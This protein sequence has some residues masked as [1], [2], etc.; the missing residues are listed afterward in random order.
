MTFEFSLAKI[1]EEVHV[2]TYYLAEGLKQ[3]DVD[4]AIIASSDDDETILKPFAILG[5]NLISQYFL[6][7]LNGATYEASGDSI[8]Y[9][10]TLNDKL[11]IDPESLSPIVENTIFEFVVHF[12]IWKWLLHIGRFDL[13]RMYEELQDG[14]F[15]EAKDNISQLAGGNR[16]RRRAT[17]LAGI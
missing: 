15:K 3:K 1:Y 4:Q 9:E 7:L 10:F 14:L 17:N 12:V 2:R 8:S 6:R 13:A 11:K 5:F 16:I